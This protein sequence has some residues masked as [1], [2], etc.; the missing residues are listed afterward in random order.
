LK[1][2]KRSGRVKMKNKRLLKRRLSSA[3]NIHKITKTMEMVAASKMRKAQELAV[4][5]KNYAEMIYEMASDLA[6][7]DREGAHKF[8]KKY[9]KVDKALVIVVST[10][11]GLCGGLNVNL[12]RFLTGWMSELKVD[13]EFINIGKKSQGFLRKYNDNFLADFSDEERWINTT[14][15]I[16]DL[17]TKKFLENEVQQV[18]ICYSQFVSALKYEPG[19]IKLLPIEKLEGRDDENKFE[20][21]I[22][23]PS[24]KEVLANLLPHYLEMQLKRAIYEAE[25]SEHSARM[26]AMKSASDNAMGLMDGIRHEYNK[27]RQQSITEEL[28][29]ITTAL[30]AIK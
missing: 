6:D 29:D 23:E 16:M 8:L 27:A 9:E 1:N 2:L 26:M 28:A 22:I 19:V 24:I 15:A 3:K 20:N 14:G 4:S 17:A 12:F 25:A 30:M 10:N 11:K 13:F 18:W 21:Y 7:I 5:G